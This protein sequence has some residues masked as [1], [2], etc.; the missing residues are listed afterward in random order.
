MRQTHTENTSI[1]DTSVTISMK[2]SDGS[3]DSDGNDDDNSTSSQ[4]EESTKKKTP[5]RK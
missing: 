3:I 5:A 1:P 4:D 2:D